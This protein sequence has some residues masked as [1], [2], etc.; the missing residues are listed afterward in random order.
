MKLFRIETSKEEFYNKYLLVVN[1]ILNLNPQ[2]IKVFGQLLYWNDKY[3]A[4][5]RPERMRLV[6]G[7]DTRKEIMKSLDITKA[8]L[9]CQLSGLRKAG[10][11]LKN[12]INPVYEIKYSTHRDLGFLFR[13]KEEED[14]E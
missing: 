3:E 11:I 5:P 10:F 6:F 4:I 1:S 8:S 2:A 7:A 13:I 9:E 12:T 14:A